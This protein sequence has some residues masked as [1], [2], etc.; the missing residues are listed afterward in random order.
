V[1]VGFEPLAFDAA[2]RHRQDQV[3]PIQA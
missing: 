1:P 2:G 3:E